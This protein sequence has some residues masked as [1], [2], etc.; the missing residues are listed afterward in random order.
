MKAGKL[1]FDYLVTPAFWHFSVW[2]LRN[3]Q[4]AGECLSQLSGMSL[5]V[6]PDAGGW[7]LEPAGVLVLENFIVSTPPSLLTQKFHCYH[8]TKL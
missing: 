1:F 8:Q 5:A 6:L 7:K 3:F 2:Y 4:R